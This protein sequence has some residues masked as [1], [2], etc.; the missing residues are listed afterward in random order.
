M[1]A[2]NYL[3]EIRHGLLIDSQKEFAEFLGIAQSQYNKYEKGYQP[4]LASAL[5]IAK[6]LNKPVEDIFYLEEDPL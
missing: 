6:R 3:R 1:N 4:T 5:K 2:K